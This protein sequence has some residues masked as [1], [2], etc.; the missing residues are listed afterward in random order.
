ML[1]PAVSRRAFVRALGVGA[2][3]AAVAGPLAACA[4]ASGARNLAYSV[5]EI[6]FGTDPNQTGELTMPYSDTARPVVV[7][8]HG[9]Y[10]RVGFTHTEMED[11]A[12][13]LARVG[14]ASWNIDYRRV[15]ER[16]GGWPGTEAD[17]A[18]GIDKLV[19][20]APEKKLDLKRVA[21][22]GHS[23][24]GQLALW[25]AAR[26]KFP[27]GTTGSSPL[28]TPRAVV[29]LSGVP[30][31][32]GSARSVLPDEA[33]LR[34]AV[35]EYLGGSPEQFPDRYAQSSPLALLPLG[36]P[37][38]LL[39][40]DDDNKVSVEQSRAYVTAATVAGDRARMLELPNVDHF[41]VVKTTKAWW[42]EVLH[43]LSAIMGDPTV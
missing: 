17:V 4:T 8:I 27:A 36:V 5:E 43:W 29:C 14:Y 35:L 20:L 40:G 30:D 1:V 39:H 9:G 34:Q 33:D 19:S 16:G 3:G 18:L 11:L 38:L 2:L 28:V 41:A 21:F 26:S 31:L 24:G 7:L 15:G 42:D 10:W 37:Q 23:A 32:L 6:P 22:M 13:D 12:K 25:A